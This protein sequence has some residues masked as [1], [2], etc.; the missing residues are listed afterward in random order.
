[1]YFTLTFLLISGVLCG[2]WCFRK[3]IHLRDD[4][5]SS[6]ADIVKGFS[7]GLLVAGIVFGLIWMYCYGR[8]LDS[9]GK[10]T[11][12]AEVKAAY[13]TAVE[14]TANKAVVGLPM[15]S[16]VLASIENYKHS[17]NTSNRIVEHRDYMKERLELRGKYKLIT[18]RWVTKQFVATPPPGLL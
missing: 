3:K 18:T 4:T 15:L 16:R 7:I 13:E 1:M 5:C 2:L 9:Y 17:T 14:D 12:S 6:P 10:L 11:V 8:S